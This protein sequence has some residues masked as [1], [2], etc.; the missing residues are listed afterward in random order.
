MHK[1]LDC[2]TRYFQVL[3]KNKRFQSENFFSKPKKTYIGNKRTGSSVFE[4]KE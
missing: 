3:S 2:Y 4:Q 1:N